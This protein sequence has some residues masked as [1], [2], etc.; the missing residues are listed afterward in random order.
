M[1]LQNASAA[2]PTPV[3]GDMRVSKVIRQYPHTYDVFRQH[4]C[5]D[6]RSGIYALSAHVMKVR[7][8]ARMHK[9]PI[10]ILLH[11]LNDAAKKDRPC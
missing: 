2:Q 7:W 9:I 11:D 1:A 6:M 5:P 3:T 8:A 4:G 10:E